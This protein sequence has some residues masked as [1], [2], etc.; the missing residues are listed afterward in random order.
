MPSFL[1]RQNKDAASCQHVRR[2]V[3][4]LYYKKKE[5]HGRSDNMT[6]VIV[7]ARL[8]RGGP[9][10]SLITASSNTVTGL[11]SDKEKELMDMRGDKCLLSPGQD[12]TWSLIPAETPHPRISEE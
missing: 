9:N 2:R 4:K 1:P 5:E 7:L 8:Q 10:M 6:N 12:E 11:F 3:F